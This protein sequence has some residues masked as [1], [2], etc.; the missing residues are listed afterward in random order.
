LVEHAHNVDYQHPDV[1]RVRNWQ[2]IYQL[3]TQCS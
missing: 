3:I 2:E 1:L